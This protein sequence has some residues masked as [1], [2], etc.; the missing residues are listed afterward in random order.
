MC[1]V[2]AP[3]APFADMVM[4]PVEADAVFMTVMAADH[5]AGHAADD[6]AGG[7]R[8]HEACARADGGA[9]D[10]AGEGRG[11]CGRHGRGRDQ[12]EDELVHGV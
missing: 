11:G 2:L 12:G 9:G 10:R 1:V 4:M 6:G 3:T 7:T 8:D 5:G